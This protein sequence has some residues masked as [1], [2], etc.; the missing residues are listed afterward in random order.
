ME[1]VRSMLRHKGSDIY[2]LA[3]EATVFEAVAMMAEKGVGA[4][5]VLTGGKLTGIVSERDYAR[6]VILKGKH[7]HEM[8]VREIMTSPVFTVTCDHSV[9]DCM[10][11]ITA[12][13]IRHLPVMEGDILAGMISIGD[14][15]RSIISAQA[16]TIDQLSGYIEG[17]YPA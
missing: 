10:R 16:H 11:I 17:R 2:W 15:V 7:S 12:H 1:T 5:L 6:K 8:R 9:E 13:R 14:V 3:P 4:L